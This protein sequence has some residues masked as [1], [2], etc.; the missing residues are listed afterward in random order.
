MKHDLLYRLALSGIHSI[1]PVYTKFLLDLFGEAEAIFRA[2]K[3]GLEKIDGMT[4]SRLT[5][6]AGFIDFSREEK[7]IA[8]LDKHSIRPLF[9]KDTDYPRR[10]L[11]DPAAPPLLFYKGNTDLNAPRIVSI[12]GTR[13]YTDYGRNATEQL[14]KGLSEHGVLVVSGLAYGIDTFAHTAALKNNL[15]TIA[16]LGNGLDTIYPP[17]N[18]GLA[19]QIAQAGGLLT[20]FGMGTKPDHFRFP[21]RNR[22]VTCMSDATVIMESGLTGGSLVTAK[23]A[24]KYQKELFAFPGRSTD[25]RSAGCNNLIKTGRAILLTDARQLLETMGWEDTT[26]MLPSPQQELFTPLS[27][28]ERTIL[29]IVK[30]KQP[31]PFDEIRRLSSLG[32]GA[33]TTAILNLELQGLIEPLPGKFYRPA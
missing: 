17:E 20:Q 4:E 31:M 5:A 2:G 3:T 9:F 1:G 33:T 26:K 28:N 10:L 11:A 25:S 18:K 8:F 32:H 15:P 27:E 21:M 13:I 16:V 22:L 12:A 19:R 7:E 14:V 6:I 24:G 23:E 30:T 29:K